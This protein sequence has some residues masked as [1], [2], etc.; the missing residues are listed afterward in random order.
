M[1]ECQLCGGDETT[2]RHMMTVATNAGVYTVYAHDLDRGEFMA[3]DDPHL[4][5]GEVECPRAQAHRLR[6]AEETARLRDGSPS[7]N[8]RL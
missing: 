4:S 8:V 6:W 5:E 2:G 7:M 1:N 3:A